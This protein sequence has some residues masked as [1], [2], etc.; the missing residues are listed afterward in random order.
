MKVS[1]IRDFLTVNNFRNTKLFVWLVLV[2]FPLFLNLDGIC[3]QKWD[4]SRYA[5]SSYEMLHG[6]NPF[7]VTYFHQP[8]MDSTKPP[9]MHW[10][11]AIF[12]AL[13]GFNE[14]AVRLPSALAGLIICLVIMRIA[15]KKFNSFSFGAIASLALLCTT[16][17]GFCGIDHSARTGDYDALLTLFLL[18]S[19]ISFYNYSEEPGKNRNLFFTFFFLMLACLT[20]GVAGLFFAPGLFLY[21][22]VTKNLLPLLKNKWTYISLGVFIGGVAFVLLMREYYNPGYLQALN[23]WEIMGRHNQVMDNHAGEFWFYL[24]FLK[25]RFGAFFWF[26][27]FGWLFGLACEDKKIRN[28]SLFTFVMC[29]SDYFVLSSAQSKLTWY[30]LPMY[31]L[32]AMQ[33][34]LFLWIILKYLS[35]FVSRK[36]PSNRFVLFYLSI[37]LIFAAPYAIVVSDCSENSYGK[38]IASFNNLQIYLKYEQPIIKNAFLLATPRDSQGQY[39]FYYYKLNEHGF[40]LTYHQAVGTYKTGDKLIIEDPVIQDAILQNYEVKEIDTFSHLKVFEI[41][42]RKDAQPAP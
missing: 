11:Q 37:V 35:A 31:P 22:M 34:A 6:G 15:L 40:N 25:E 17:Q 10:I 1:L 21:A 42:K 14:T 29:A 28:F 33:G 18:L 9:L 5:D 2:Y 3:M 36:I 12:I 27:V 20:K 38:T 39:L 13:F 32:L 41:L 7:V 8:S 19:A 16:P 26:I 24:V 23:D 30:S 4:E